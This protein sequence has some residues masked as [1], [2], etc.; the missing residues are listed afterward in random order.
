M[1]QGLT[2]RQEL[3]SVAVACSHYEGIGQA[4]RACSFARPGA[5]SVLEST[6]RVDLVAH[7]LPEPWLQVPF[8]DR[9]GFIGRA[10]MF[11]R[12][13]GVVGEVD[14]RVK[15]TQPYPDRAP[16]EI[17][18]AEK[19]RMERMQAAGLE[20]VG[21]TA[22]EM[23]ASPGAVVG[24]IYAAAGRAVLLSPTYRVGPPAGTAAL[25]G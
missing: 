15:Y 8:Y 25:A 16:E 23:L 9:R 5:E 14:G 13:L 19:R 20:V 12:E 17:L 24:R 7:G 2:V 3:A 10:D 22:A 1:K 4:A 6:S 18:W 21:W 11:W